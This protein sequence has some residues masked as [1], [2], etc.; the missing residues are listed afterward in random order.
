MVENS[1]Y[2]K[3]ALADIR[4]RAQKD[5]RHGGLLEAGDYADLSR[6]AVRTRVERDN[7]YT[8]SQWH[9]FLTD[10]IW[11]EIYLEVVDGAE[12]VIF[13]LKK[14]MQIHEI[15]VVTAR[16]LVEATMKEHGWSYIVETMLS[17][18]KVQIVLARHK[19]VIFNL[20]YSSL[21][22]DIERMETAM[23][24]LMDIFTG[25][26]CNIDISEIKAKDV[27]KK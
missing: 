16:C 19:K 5:L 20:K 8:N 22:E 17:K 10:K 12:K 18:V 25:F 6:R 13:D 2:I 1:D 3:V 24:Q 23:Q 26:G 14:K 7:R 15:D 11:G 4:H 9:E 21:A 27:W